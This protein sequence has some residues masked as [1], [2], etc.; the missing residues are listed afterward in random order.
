MFLFKKIY[1]M[2]CDNLN[3]KNYK[4]ENKDIFEYDLNKNIINNITYS[5]G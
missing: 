2:V 4:L 5:D 1:N 3:E